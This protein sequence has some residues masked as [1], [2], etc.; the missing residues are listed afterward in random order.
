LI[1]LAVGVGDG[2]GVWVG[3]GVRVRVGVGDGPSDQG[4]EA[5]HSGEVGPLLAGREIVRVDDVGARQ[6]DVGDDRV[7]PRHL[8]A[9]VDAPYLED[10]LALEAVAAEGDRVAGVVCEDDVGHRLPPGRPD[11]RVKANRV[12]ADVEVVV[13]ALV[14]LQSGTHRGVE[15]SRR[16]GAQAAAQDPVRLDLAAHD[17]GAGDVAVGEGERTGRLDEVELGA[18]LDNHAVDQLRGPADVDALAVEGRWREIH[19]P[20]AKED[21]RAGLRHSAVDRRRRERGHGQA[22]GEGNVG[23]PGHGSGRHPHEIGTRL[24]QYSPPPDLVAQF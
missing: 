17:G 7:R 9:V 16:R 19:Y 5:V 1:G 2:W 8:P 21:V 4:V 20:P 3:A 6:L 11:G 24:S 14:D 23:P 18:G 15:H 22:Y 13:H 10:D 12:A